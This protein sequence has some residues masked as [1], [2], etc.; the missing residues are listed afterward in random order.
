[1]LRNRKGLSIRK[2]SSLAGVDKN[3][4][5]RLERGLPVRAASFERVCAALGTTPGRQSL[6]LAEPHR[7]FTVSRANRRR[8][9]TDPEMMSLSD[10]QKYDSETR[11]LELGWSKECGGFNGFLD[12]E[13]FGGILVSSLIELFVMSTLRSFPGEEFIYCLR[14]SILLLVGDEQVI[15]DEG[16]AVSLWAIEPHRAGP[17]LPVG[18]GERPPLILSVRAAGRGGRR[19][20]L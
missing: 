10:P 17:L 16:D 9:E 5:L 12:C 18:I 20:A 1:L 2:L 3:T 11:R 7:S 4:C 19:K 13:L 8:W 6:A 14:G 15:L